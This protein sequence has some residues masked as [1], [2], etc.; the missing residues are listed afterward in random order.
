VPADGALQVA[1]VAKSIKAA[2]FSVSLTRGKQKRQIAWF[3]GFHET[4]FQRH[5]QSIR[6]T[7]ADKSGGADCVSRLNDC[8]RFCHGSDLVTHLPS[9]LVIARFRPL[10]IAITRPRLPTKMA[11]KPMGH[12]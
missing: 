10:S 5:Q 7:D 9:E 8:D 1:L 3:A 4:P 2:I 12:R 6:D 11:L